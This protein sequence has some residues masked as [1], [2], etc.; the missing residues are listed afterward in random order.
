MGR[1][2]VCGFRRARPLLTEDEHAAPVDNSGVVVTGGWRSASG[3]GSGGAHGE[4]TRKPSPTA[5]DSDMLFL[6]P[7][8]SPALLPLLP[9]L[10]FSSHGV[11]AGSLG[12]HVLH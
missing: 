11:A 7:P 5:L 1:Q 4:V 6:S 2:A 3:E 10:C 9:L 8:P 12:C